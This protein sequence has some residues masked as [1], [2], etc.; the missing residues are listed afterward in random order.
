MK[1]TTVANV[2]FHLSSLVA[3]VEDG[4][5]L[6]ITGR[7]KPVGRLITEPRAAKLDW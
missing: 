2:K 3:E 1:S 6:V 5:N 7:G 4:K